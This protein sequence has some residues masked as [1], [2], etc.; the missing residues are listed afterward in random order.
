MEDREIIELFWSR[1][2]SAVSV[3]DEKYGEFCRHIAFNILHS[4][5]DSEECVNDTYLKVWNAIPPQRPTFLRAFLSRI[6]R[7]LAFDRCRLKMRE[8]RG[9]GEVAIALSELEN[10]IS[11]RADVQEEYDTKELGEAIG[12][13][14]RTISER[15]RDVFVARYY[16]VT[17]VEEISEKL[18]IDVKQVWNI[19]SRTRKKLKDFLEKEGYRI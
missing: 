4:Q 19:L 6:T 10:C 3:L 2:E 1:D 12:R 5:E 14:L 16:F 11:S 15:D 13:F 17:E 9:G 8:K 18:G 7:N